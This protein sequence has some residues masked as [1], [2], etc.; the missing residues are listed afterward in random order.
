[1]IFLLSFLFLSCFP[2]INDMIPEGP[3]SYPGQNPREIII[4]DPSNAPLLKEATQNLV[5]RLEKDILQTTLQFVREELFDIMNCDDETVWAL[6]DQNSEGKLEPEIPLELF[7]KEK[8]GVCRHIAL[9]T[10]Y[11]IDHLIKKE[12]LTGE[13]FLIREQTPFGRHAWTLLLTE[14]GAWH[15]DAYWGILENGRTDEG[16]FKLCRKYG[17]RVMER[18][19]Q[20][21]M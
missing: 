8:V 19:K 12:I 11:L 14:E 10:T 15:L 7:L 1:M 13:V 9:T 20:R 3:F 18:Q 2:E 17:T 21:W 6:I 16:F 5:V 4:V